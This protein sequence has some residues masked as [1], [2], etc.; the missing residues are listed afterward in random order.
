MRIDSGTIGMESE[1][2]YSAK[3]VRETKL[4][5]TESRKS[6]SDGAGSLLGDLLTSDGEEAN[7]AKEKESSGDYVTRTMEEM[8]AK[9]EAFRNRNIRLQ[10]LEDVQKEYKDI[11]QRCLE[12]LMELFFPSKREETAYEKERSSSFSSSAGDGSIFSGSTSE[13]STFSQ[14]A[15]YTGLS[16]GVRSTTAVSDGTLKAIAGSN[17]RTFTFSR[18]YSYEETEN[19]VFMTRGTVRCADGREISFNL[20]AEMSR[21]F[22]EYYEENY[23]AVQAS[24]Y[25]PLVINLDGNIAELSDQTFFFDID[26]DGEMDEINELSAGSGYLAL[27]KNGDGIINDGSELFGTKSGD[28]FADLAAYDQDGNGFIDEGDEIFHKLKIWTVDEKGN[29]Q[30]VSLLDKGV[31]AIC[32]QNVATDFK[33]ANEQNQTKGMIRKTGI[34]LYENGAVGTIQH[35]DVAKYDQAG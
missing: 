31:G 24:L 29:K 21:S 4:T 16:V 3:S 26:A 20:N 15:V 35:V 13:S 5:I 30:L 17:L 14:T 8:N 28:G 33:L 11:R 18:A 22:Q 32:L 23:L 2:S 27:D 6:L 34:F 1:R 10:N 25:D 9:V 7:Q 12:F 19:T